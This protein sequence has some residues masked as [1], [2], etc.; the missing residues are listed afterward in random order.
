MAQA[1]DQLTIR[2]IHGP[3]M[4]LLTNLQGDKGREWLTALNKFL[5]KENPWPKRAQEY[6]VW[7]TITVGQYRSVQS[8]RDLL[9]SHR[10]RLEEGTLKFLES[11]FQPIEKRTPVDLV[12]LTLSELG[13]KGSVFYYRQVVAQGIRLGFQLCSVET[14]LALRLDYLEQPARESL[15]VAVHGDWP[16]TAG[17]HP[18]LN[19]MTIEVNH[20][21]FDPEEDCGERPFDRLELSN[22]PEWA[23]NQNWYPGNKIVFVRPRV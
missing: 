13:L 15:N 7:R 11:A 21:K 3:Y 9:K 16:L 22:R 17:P 14:A 18:F 1:G 19:G 4:Q 10:I 8:Y 6:Q 20:S 23:H 5:V 2:E 12:Q